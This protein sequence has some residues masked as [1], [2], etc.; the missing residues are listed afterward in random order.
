MTIQNQ[1][2]KPNYMKLRAENKSKMKTLNRKSPKF[3]VTE[4][5]MKLN[6]KLN[7]RFKLNLT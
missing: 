6:L 7:L 1:Q 5:K 4:T 3:R 2:F